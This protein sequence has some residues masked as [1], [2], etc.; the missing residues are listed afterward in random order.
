[1]TGEVHLT[2][3]GEHTLEINV[4]NGDDAFVS[5]TQLP[6]RFR[7]SVLNVSLDDLEAMAATITEY[8]ADQRAQS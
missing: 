5:A 1:M 7:T 2:N 6:S 4:P 8:V 3:R